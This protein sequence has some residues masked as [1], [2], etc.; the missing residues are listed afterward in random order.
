MGIDAIRLVVE[1]D[2]NAVN[3]LITDR[4]QSPLKL[5]NDIAEHIIHSGG[6]RLR[7]LLLLLVSRACNYQGNEHVTLAAMI[8]F[9]H[10][11]TLLHD[12]VLDESTLRRGRKTANALWGNK[13]SILAGDFLFVKHL[14]LMVEIGDIRIIQ[15]MIDIAPQIGSS[16]IQQLSDSSTPN[17]NVQHYFDSIQAKTA[18]LFAAASK[19]GTLISKSDTTIQ[20][21]L[22]TYGLEVGNAFQLID[23]AMDYSSNAETMGKNVG[24][25]LANSKATLPLLYALDQGNK[26]QKK[27]IEESLKQGSLEML[28]QVLQVLAET[29]AINYTYH[30]AATKIDAALSALS[31]LPE[32]QYKNALEQLAQHVLERNS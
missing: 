27:V 16:E 14:E 24:D 18:L 15:L 17:M 26:A 20:Q 3:K 1:E 32:S 23:D 13:A 7:S 10:T 12:D 4:V 30:V 31:V 29:D 19:I 8:E 22:Y 11:A 2:F 6:K 21:G 5:V 25:D 9:F 28:P